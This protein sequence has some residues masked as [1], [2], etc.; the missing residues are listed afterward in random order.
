MSKNVQFM[1]FRRVDGTTIQSRGGATVAYKLGKDGKVDKFA[2]AYCSDRDNY[3]R[4]L[5][6]NLSSG[7]LQYS[8]LSHNNGIVTETP[9]AFRAMME[10]MFKQQGLSRPHPHA[11][12]A[13][14]RTG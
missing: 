7:R 10:D 6:R 5:G 12:R 3:S 9:A 8:G 4:A 2:I 14:D 1:H 11:R 13:S